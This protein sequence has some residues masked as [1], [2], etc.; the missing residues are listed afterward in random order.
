MFKKKRIFC[1]IELLTESWVIRIDRCAHCSGVSL[2]G[3]IPI[4][5][6]NRPQ[7]RSIRSARL[8]NRVLAIFFVLKHLL[9]TYPIPKTSLTALPK[10]AAK[11]I[12]VLLLI[13]HSVQFESYLPSLIYKKLHP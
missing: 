8:N 3:L 4:A 10:A 7:I 13:N 12:L 2:G 1:R 6:R 9:L 11:Q 5:P